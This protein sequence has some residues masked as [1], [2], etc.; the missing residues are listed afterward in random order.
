MLS[1]LAIVRTEFFASVDAR[2]C[3]ETEASVGLPRHFSSAREIRRRRATVA[4]FEHQTQQ[5]HRL[6]VLRRP[7]GEQVDLPP[8]DE[9]LGLALYSLRPLAEPYPTRERGWTPRADSDDD[10]YSLS[11]SATPDPATP[12]PE[13]YVDDFDD[14]ECPPPLPVSAGAGT[15]PNDAHEPVSDAATAEQK[16]R[17]RIASMHNILL[18][19]ERDS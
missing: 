16:I 10:S 9:P 3:H 13:D 15:Y 1:S 19:G 4:E 14:P 7:V 5:R 8:Q 6:K 17:E 2:K 18:D 11:L 12:Q